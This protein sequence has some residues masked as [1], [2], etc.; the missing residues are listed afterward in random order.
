MSEE[1][2]VIE[3]IKKKL[4]SMKE[5]RKSRRADRKDNREYAKGYRKEKKEERKQGKQIKKNWGKKKVSRKFVKENMEGKTKDLDYL[6]T[7]GDGDGSVRD[8]RKGINKYRKKRLQRNLDKVGTEN[9]VMTSGGDRRVETKP[10]KYKETP[11][12]YRKNKKY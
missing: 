11:R 2:T 8:I 6:F 1:T 5:K 3:K 10:S 4:K 7:D 9:S 12:Q